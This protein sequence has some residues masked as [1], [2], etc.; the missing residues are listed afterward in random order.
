[1]GHLLL[2]VLHMLAVATALPFHGHK[3]H[4]RHTKTS[5]L[6]SGWSCLQHRGCCAHLLFGRQR[7]LQLDSHLPLHSSC[8]PLV[9]GVQCGYIQ[10]C[11]RPLCKHLQEPSMS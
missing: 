7:L 4:A 10:L 6:E 5:Q 3:P 2:K 1:M 9:Q 8:I 11:K